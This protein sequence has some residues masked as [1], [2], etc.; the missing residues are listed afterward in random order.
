MKRNRGFLEISFAWLFAIIVGAVILMLAIFAATKI[1]NI[2]QY[3]TAAQTQNQIA[4]LLNPLETS[5]ESGQLTSIGISTK[6]RIY[7]Q[8]DDQTG[9]FGNQII[10]TSQQSLGSWSAPTNGAAFQNKYIF[11]GGIVKGQ[12]F[13]LFSKPFSFPFK[14]SDVIYMTSSLTNYCF[15][16]PPPDT[17]TELSKLNEGNILLT[18]DTQNCPSTSMKVC[19]S[20]ENC[21]INVNLQSSQDPDSYEG[22]VDKN[23]SAAVTFYSDAL[24]YGAIFSD[25][26]TYECQL[27]RLMERESQLSSLYIAKANTLS[28]IG[29]NS[30]L[31]SDLTNLGSLVDS[32][33]NSNNDLD[34]I[35]TAIN[36]I[37]SKNDLL[38]AG[39]SCKLW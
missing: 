22:T 2:G 24:M 31:V 25:N 5:F 32:F 9:T 18:N 35:I 7:N 38:G 16:N 15:V 39:N 13:Y 36:N 23:D 4:V 12:Q 14:I 21:D 3:S 20:G 8:C 27:K 37:E 6:T 19:F 34:N 1:I 11:S 10:S 33:K 17:Q 28:Q 29:C 26:S 30:N